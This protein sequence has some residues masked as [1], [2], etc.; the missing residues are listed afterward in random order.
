MAKS[1]DEDTYEDRVY[2]ARANG[3]MWL[4]SCFKLREADK[5]IRLGSFGRTSNLEL[6]WMALSLSVSMLV[7]VGLHYGL[8]AID[9]P[10]RFMY[11]WISTVSFPFLLGWQGRKLAH[12][13]PLRK[14]TGEGMGV[15][16]KLRIAKISNRLSWI[17]GKP[18]VYNT[19]ETRMGASDYKIREMPAIEWIGTQRAPT[20]PHNITPVRLATAENDY[21]PEPP[22]T[23]F[24]EFVPRVRGTGIEFA[25]GT[26]S[27]GIFRSMTTLDEGN[28]RN[29]EARRKILESIPTPRDA[30]FDSML[31]E[32]EEDR[33]GIEGFSL[34]GPVKT[35]S[36]SKRRRSIKRP[37]TRGRTKR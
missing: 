37:K 36:K 24:R 30:E 15:Y 20:A 4:N 11:S 1:E 13:S 23:A 34:D 18:T 9:A 35:K 31:H 8:T 5:P 2:R 14:T 32:P 17:G 12:F 27:D 19:Y 3:V 29:S 21:A 28:Y 22:R 26:Y 33:F 25:N 6:F 7:F 16:L 10:F